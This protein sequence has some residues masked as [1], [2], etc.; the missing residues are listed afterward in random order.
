[1][2]LSLRNSML[3]VSSKLVFLSYLDHA[4]SVDML[5]TVAE[6]QL[7]SLTNAGTQT[8]FFFSPQIN[9]SYPEKLNKTSDKTKS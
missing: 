1:M 2:E 4:K 6:D 5:N 7:I 3:F 8:N 9:V